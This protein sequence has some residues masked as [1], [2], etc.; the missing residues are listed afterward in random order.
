MSVRGTQPSTAARSQRWREASLPQ[1]SSGRPLTTPAAARRQNRWQPPRPPAAARQQSGQPRPLSR[2]RQQLPNGT[3]GGKR[4]AAANVGSRPPRTPVTKATRTPT[5][6]EALRRSCTQ[7]T[8]AQ[9]ANRGRPLSTQAAARR[10]GGQTPPPRQCQQPPAANAGGERHLIANASS[11][12]PLSPAA[13]ATAPAPNGH[14][15]TA[16]AAVDH[17]RRHPESPPTSDRNCPKAKL[18]TRATPPSTPAAARRQLSV[19]AS[20]PPAPSA[21]DHQRRR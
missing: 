20:R 16:P 10:Q 3:A 1:Q 8:T 4:H 18:V 17:Q 21:A 14:L 19:S 9:R 15:R 6:E 12:P 5:P 13:H 7:R 11:R 2:Q